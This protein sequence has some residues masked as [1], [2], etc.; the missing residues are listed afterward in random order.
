MQNL[1]EKLYRQE[2]TIGS[3]LTVANTIVAEIMACSGFDWLAV[4]LEHSAISIEMTQ[5]LIRVIELSGVVPLVRVS[6][7]EPVVIKRVMDAG[8]SG[9]IVP[10]VNSRADAERAVGSVKYPPLGFRG[11]GLARAQQY[12]CDFTGY[13]KWNQ[14]KSVVIVQIEHIEAVINLRD[15]LSVEGVDGYLIGP[16]DLSASLGVP[17]QLEHPEVLAAMQ[18]IEDI[19]N[20]LG[21]L[22]G[23]HV[24]SPEYEDLQSKVFQGYRFIAHSLDI[25]ILGNACRTMTANYGDLY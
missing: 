23:Y 16:Y 12:G 13:R 24:I 14:E 9:V 3:W 20:E 22:S 21:A 15:I 18:R 1:K 11:A 7:N 8:A 25:L 17:G 4:D 5:E 2:L 19:S 10:M 6:H